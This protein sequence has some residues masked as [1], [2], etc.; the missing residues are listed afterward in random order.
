MESEGQ[1]LPAVASSYI[2]FAVSDSLSYLK[3]WFLYFR[4]IESYSFILKD[5]KI[6][7]VLGSL[8]RQSVLGSNSGFY[9]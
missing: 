1:I 2:F 9:F 7:T 8:K 6:D 4:F 3:A 5:L